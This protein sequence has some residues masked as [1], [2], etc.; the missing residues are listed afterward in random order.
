[1][2]GPL[3]RL[4]VDDAKIHG[5]AG[6]GVAIEPSGSRTVRATI[7]D[8]KI[9]DNASAGIRLKPASGAIA[10]AVVRRSQI[11]EN[12]NGLIVDAAGGTAVANVFGTAI[13]D[14]GLDGNGLGYGV[15]SNGTAA[16][17][18]ISRDEIVSNTRGLLS[19]GGRILSTGDNDIF[20]NVVNGAPTGTLTRG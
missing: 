10:R 15:Y 3:S 5:N 17:V 9:D 7:R 13:T 4:F 11:D 18:R 12:Y 8:S 16:T 14:S 20:G 19:N 1:M 6:P 2:S